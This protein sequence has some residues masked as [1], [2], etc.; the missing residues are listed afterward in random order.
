[1]RSKRLLAKVVFVMVSILLLTTVVFADGGGLWLSG[2]QGRHN[3]R[4][5]DTESKI[6]TENVS[7]LAPLWAITTGD[8]P[9]GARD[10]VSAT[11][12]VDG[13]YVYFPDWSGNLFKADR[14]TGEVIWKRQI[15]EYTGIPGDFA[16]TTPAIYG[17]LLIFGTQSGQIFTGPQAARVVAVDKM[18]GNA[19]WT[20][21]ADDYFGSIITQS[22]VVFDGRVYVGVSSLE[23]FWAAIIPGYEC[24]QLLGRNIQM[25]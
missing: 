12:S 6:N 3:N 9:G 17:D 5:Q 18:S 19:V 20:T 10:D 11:P 16:R 14:R 13:E 7:N 25:N 24:C 2:G 15:S 8:G 4:Y 23:E 1:M 21:Q 22:A